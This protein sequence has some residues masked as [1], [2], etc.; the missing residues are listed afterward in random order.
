MAVLQR[1][2]IPLH[3]RGL[4]DVQASLGA[5]LLIDGI[6]DTSFLL[7]GIGEAEDVLWAPI[8]FVLTRA[9]FG[10]GLVA[11][12]DAVKEALPGTDLLP[13]ATIAWTLQNIFP[14]SKLAEAA[15]LGPGPNGNA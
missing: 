2:P 1:L 8:S 5:A 10:S 11:S 14:D 15:G 7:P 13:V 12:F 6:G 4:A 9:L 3:S